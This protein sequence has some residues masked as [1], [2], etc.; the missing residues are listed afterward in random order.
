MAYEDIPGGSTFG[1]NRKRLERMLGELYEGGGQQDQLDLDELISASLKV[2]D[3]ESGNYMEVE[4]DGTIVNHGDGT[5][6]DD[7]VNSLIG[8]RLYSN[9]GKVD[10]D[11]D[12]NAL[13][14]QPSGSITNANDRVIWSLQYPHAAIV[15]GEMRLHIHWEQP[16]A[17]EREFT[18]AYRIQSN[19]AVKET[20]WTT[21][22]VPTSAA[23]NA[24]TYVS[25]TLNQITS[26][27]DVDMTDAGISSTVQFRLARTD[28]ESGNILGT[29]V[30]AHV[31]MDTLGSR[32]EY[33][34]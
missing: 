20:D 18:V 21:V 12:E 4:D 6:W 2:G 25:G 13:V 27:V 23:N 19:G 3:I 9:S 31:E 11:Y 5:V 26:L 24:F 22:V 14:F 1:L 30:D 34:K 16:D 33:V 29:F 15:D 10:Y 28:S 32:D 17:T 7:L 8:R